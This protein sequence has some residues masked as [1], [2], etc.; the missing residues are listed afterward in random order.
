MFIFWHILGL[1]KTMLRAHRQAWA[2]QDE[3]HGLTL[4]DIRAL[5]RETQL[6]L[7]EKMANALS[8]NEGGAAINTA[9]STTTSEPRQDNQI[10]NN[11][12]NNSQND[13]IAISNE[14]LINNSGN[15]TES[16]KPQQNDSFGYHGTV[17][18][19]MVTSRRSATDLKGSI[20][21]M[22]VNRKQ[23]WSSTR[24]RVSGISG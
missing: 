16:F 6:A 22:G 10:V 8:E 23:S 24:S 20:S 17:A 13:A 5:E 1:R 7:Q 9:A 14:Q 18:K 21:S 2:W 15:T 4:D 12:N 19:D 3:Y 11:Q